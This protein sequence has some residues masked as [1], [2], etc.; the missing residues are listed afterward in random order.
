MVETR[1]AVGCVWSVA[2]YCYAYRFR[3]LLLA[4][5]SPILAVPPLV[6]PLVMQEMI[7]KAYPARDLRLFGWLCLAFA[8]LGVL[9]VF[10]KAVAGYLT[11][12]VQTLTRY[13]LSIRIL[14]AILRLPQWYREEHDPGML[15][16]RSTRDVCSVTQNLMKLVP[17]LVTIVI[18]F[19]AVIPL[20]FRLNMR[21]ALFALA[22]VPV[23]YLITICLSRRLIRLQEASRKIDEKITSFTSETIAGVMIAR[24]FLLNRRRRKRLKELLRD[25]L[26]LTF[27][28]WR[29]STF[30]GVCGGLIS[31]AWGLVFICGGWY[32]VFTDR[33]QL[34]QAVALGMYVRVLAQP[35]SELGRVYESLMTDSVAARRVLEILHQR[36]SWTPGRTQKVLKGPPVCFE[37]HGVSFGYRQDCRCLHDVDL[38]LQS[39][40]TVAIVGPSGAGK[41]T[42]MRILSGMDDRYDGR[43]LVDGQDFRAIDPDSYLRYVSLVPQTTFFFSDSIRDNLC[44]GD[45]MVSS[46]HLQAFANT[47]GLMEVI[48]AAPDGYDTKLGS[49][50]IRLSAGQYQKLAVLRAI[51]KHASI[52]LLD[53]VTSSMDIE[54]ER[55]LLRGVVALR[56]PGCVT[57]LVTHHIDITCEPWIDTILVMRDGRI[58]ERGSCAQLQEKSGFYCRWLTLSKG[59]SPVSSN[60]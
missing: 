1:R 7:D 22:I 39:G 59:G 2:R 28:S 48:A 5:L 54:S 30:W 16:E 37:L 36:P 33:L 19:L 57:L 43:F 35:F 41:S 9:P 32:L 15:L 17:E 4:L 14:N 53:E 23:N 8:F 31:I 47:L 38:Q 60:A 51:L 52:L 50:G 26:R 46:T 49:E 40:Q 58:V 29:T 21:I 44:A 10:C 6:T 20:M 34:G 56:P 27:A 45:G 25:H 3:V 11:T 18:T 24:I 55:Q 12:Y 42:L 13:K